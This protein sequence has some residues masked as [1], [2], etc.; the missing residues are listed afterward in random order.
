MQSM[1]FWPLVAKKATEYQLSM[2]VFAE[3]ACFIPSSI[4]SS[5]LLWQKKCGNAFFVLL[6]LIQPFFLTGWS[7]QRS[8]FLS[9]C[10][11]S[12]PGHTNTTYYLNY[13]EISTVKSL[14][15]SIIFKQLFQLSTKTRAFPTYDCDS[16][17]S[18]SFYRRFPLPLLPIS[19]NG[20]ILCV[21]ACGGPPP[22]VCAL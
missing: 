6:R 15:N 4:V 14:P 19:P 8:P 1:S 21:C 5:P 13:G 10:L 20:L 12:I 17:V 11:M 18:A 2:Q 16:G 22:P 7:H 9:R 3:N